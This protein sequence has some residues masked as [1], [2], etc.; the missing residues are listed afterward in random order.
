MSS[1]TNFLNLFKWNSIEDGEEEFDID[2]AL[3]DNWDKID[4]KLETHIKG[5]NKEVSDFKTEVNDNFDTFKQQTNKTVQ[6]LTDDVSGKVDKISGKG[7]STNDFT[8][9]LKQKLD[10]IGEG[11]FLPT[12]GT[13][14]QVLAKASDSDGDVEWVEQTGGSGGAVINQ[15]NVEMVTA[16]LTASQKMTTTE[17]WQAVKVNFDNVTDTES[18]I[19]QDGGIKIGKG[20][21]KILVSANLAFLEA[22]T[23]R[24]Q[25]LIRK[26]N[27]TVGKYIAKEQ[28]N[29]YMNL[30]MPVQVIDVTEGDII[31]LITGSSNVQ[32]GKTIVK[33]ITYM[34]IVAIK[35]E[36]GS[37]Y[38]DI[39]VSPT[40]PQTDRRK[41]WF[42]KG[43]DTNTIY[44][45][46]DNGEY[47]E[48]IKREEMTHT[49]SWKTLS[50]SSIDLNY[51]KVDTDVELSMKYV[52]GRGG[53]IDIPAY[54]TV[55]V[56]TLPEGYRPK[57]VLYFPVFARNS[58]T[59]ANRYLYAEIK[60]SGEILLH[61]GYYEAVSVDEVY[62]F[63]K[64]S[65]L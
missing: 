12:G 53:M 65:V 7:L 2:K 49:E 50:F 41:V 37:A 23:G 31:T 15:T 26:N 22:L 16:A 45:K 1:F 19:L 6:D 35:D 39:I 60:L 46:N 18:L 30:T 11:S 58:K 55:S 57:N 10:D 32:T 64:Y 42:Q 43:E 27:T 9:D 3:N 20:I 17:A 13:T 28:N 8:D 14:G 24:V 40:E 34:T 52:W 48:F 25:I 5:V 21:S 56:G 61:S 54:N 59:S 51:R 38:G 62:G 44:V 36:T 47:E 33:D 29:I 63:I 4:I